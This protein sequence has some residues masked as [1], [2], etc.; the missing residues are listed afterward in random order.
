[1]ASLAANTHANKFVTFWTTFGFAS[2]LQFRPWT[3][4][5]A[6]T[7]V[8]PVPDETERII[9]IN[10]CERGKLNPVNNTEI[11]Q[12]FNQKRVTQRIPP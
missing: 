6:N 7:L 2:Q 12:V 8:T 1:M 10:I 5:H 9:L 3:V 4:N 11:T